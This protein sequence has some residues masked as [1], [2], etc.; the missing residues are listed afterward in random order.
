MD[1][2]DVTV[3]GLGV[4]GLP[5]AVAAA[6]AGLRVIGLDSSPG[7]IEDIRN[8]V[9]G[10]GL[11]TVSD[12]LLNETLTG[13]LLRVR[14]TSTPTPLSRTYVVCVPTPSGCHDGADLTALFAAVD[15]IA[16]KVRSGDLVLVQSTC[17]P[18]TVERL[19]I[20]RMAEHCDARPGVD[21]FLAYS[22]VRTNPGPGAANRGAAP[23]VLGGMSPQCVRAAA[24]FLERLGECVVPVSSVRVAELVKVF[25]N[26]FR[27]VNISLVNEL[28]DV[29]RLASVEVS[30][31]LDAA[32]TKPS[33]FLR[34]D[35]GPGA[36]G[37]CLPV[38]AGMLVAAS[39]RQ[40]GVASVAEAALDLNEAMPARTLHLVR[41]LLAERRMPP[42]RGG[43]VLIVGV[44]YKPD[45]PDVRRSAA[46]RMLERLRGEAIVTYHDPYVPRL[47]LGDGEVLC[48]QDLEPVATDLVLLLTRHHVLDLP[49]L[50]GC[51]V[52]V[53]DCSTGQ[54]RLVAA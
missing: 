40:A 22:P 26:T 27:L 18:G 53:I 38:S 24:S 11:T 1:M 46:V 50:L 5:T 36:G 19:V 31:V 34:H 52:P 16:G 51:G 3:F 20:P 43:R 48:G 32:E 17:P 9:P 41:C 29:C 4:T 23:R 37:D 54:P 49:R 12:R 13:G 28:A 8:V 45:V 35:P 39:R 7:R 10:A 30:E 15:V 14:D 44:T 42:L 21:Y 2:V 6:A 47:E 33:T 25:E